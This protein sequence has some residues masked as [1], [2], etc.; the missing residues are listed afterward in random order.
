MKFVSDFKELD[1]K[2]FNS[3]NECKDAEAAILKQR[4]ELAQKEKD[5][6]K[7]KKKLANEIDKAEEALKTAYK[8]YEEAKATAIKILDESN[9]Q[10]LDL[11]T[12]AEEAVK[13]A[14]E[15]KAEAIKRFNK[16]CGVY[17]KVYT[18]TEAEEEFERFT[19]V[20]NSLFND[21]VRS[22]RF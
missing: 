16:E 6:S 3:I 22:W 19:Q 2:L 13:K 1:G 5:R 12:P 20:F 11:L 10:V 21:I 7:Q 14:E 8:N 15:A 4:E 17:Q 9:K 18:G